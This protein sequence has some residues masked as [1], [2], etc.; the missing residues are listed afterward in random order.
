MGEWKRTCCVAAVLIAIDLH[1]W[2]KHAFDHAAG[3]RL[4]GDCSLFPEAR[5]QGSLI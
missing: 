4:Q 1:E 3:M 2:D 5:H